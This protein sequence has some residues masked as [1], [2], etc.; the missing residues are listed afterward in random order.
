MAT[1]EGMNNPLSSAEDIFFAALERPAEERVLFVAALTESRNTLRAEVER[2]LQAHRGLG[3]FLERPASADPGFAGAWIGRYQLRQTLGEGG[4]GVVFLAEQQE[5]FR[6]HVAVKVIKPGMDTR[7]VIA[8]FEAERQALALMN[9][10]HIAQVFDAG[11]TAGGR[12]YFVMELV[13]G[14]PCTRFCDEET[15]TLA[16]RLQLFVK[17]C[18][19]IGH[20]HAK[21]IIHRDIKPANILVARHDGEAVPKVIDFGIAKAT[22]FRLTDRTLQTSVTHFIGTPAYMSPEQAG[23]G[24][25]D[26]RSDIYSLGVVLY[27]L[28]AGCTPFEREALAAG[29]P[30]EIRRRIREDEPPKLAARVAALPPDVLRA[31]AQQRKTPAAQLPALLRGEL[32]WLVGRCLEKDPGRRFDS[33][34]ALADEVERYLRGEKI[35]TTAPSAFTRWSRY[36]RSHG[37]ARWLGAAAAAALE[38]WSSVRRQGATGANEADPGGKSI[39]AEARAASRG[40]TQDVEAY[41]AY[42]DGRHALDQLTKENIERSI[43]C[44]ERALARDANFALAWVG[45]AMAHEAL[46][47]WGEEGAFGEA[48]EAARRA[49]GKAL[50]IEPE[51]ADAH[52]ALAKVQM[53]YD[54]DWPA[55][56][57]SLRRALELAPTNVSVW[58]TAAAMA[59]SLGQLERALSLGRRAVELDPGLV[60]AHQYLAMILLVSGQHA[61]AEIEANRML[62]L[63][64]EADVAHWVLCVSALER[65]QL[66][67]A[68]EFA[69]KE[70]DAAFRLMLLGCVQHARGAAAESDAA[71]AELVRDHEVQASYQIAQVHGF[72]GNRDAAFVW[73]E[74]AFRRHDAGLWWTKVDPSLRNLHRD[75]RW[76]ALLRRLR[77]AE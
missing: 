53:G 47:K 35:T 23:S 57:H 15:L 44:F 65:R 74:W 1:D 11:T 67:R 66:D 70:K 48:F 52:M 32:E 2:L 13:T 21:R 55:A 36:T 77:L 46:A 64:P 40:R 76:P 28:L 62:T 71:L 26:V 69:R 29:S 58:V 41:R 68:L 4:V 45:L 38:G 60:A 75:A 22:E 72:R 18:R 7:E 10:P 5:P 24:P 27:Q 43:A 59:M 25:I 50:A 63:S 73:L 17:I 8:R 51:L 30:E 37:A 16:E 12:P 3:N 19:A 61:E 6:R 20:A 49:A 56:E 31:T 9:H 39:D 54:W 42:L 34:V 14:R 33:A